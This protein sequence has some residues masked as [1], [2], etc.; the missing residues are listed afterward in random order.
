MGDQSDLTPR[1]RELLEH[2]QARAAAGEPPP[3]LDQ[4]CRG[5]GCSSRGSMHKHVAGLIAAGLVEPMAGRHRG[6]RLSDAAQPSGVPLLGT[7]A[8]GRP[9]EAVSLPETIDLPDWLRPRGR[10]YALR[11]R[12][13]SMIEEGIHDG[14]VVIVE[15]REHAENGELVVAL[16]D[17]AEVT[18]KRL[19]KSAGHVTLIP[20][21]AALEPWTLEASRVAIQG[22]VS[23]LLR[24]YGR[25][26]P[27]RSGRG[28]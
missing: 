19:R 6:V 9:I 21:N 20:A 5:L 18:L 11:V 7:I 27:T 15:A 26:R 13:E 10:A 25:V 3:S 24:S 28:T 17:A 22:V 8:A 12:G 16:V 14:D 1:Q 2:L 23:G 4:L